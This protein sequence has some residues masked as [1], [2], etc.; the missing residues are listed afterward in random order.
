MDIKKTRT[1]KER[2]ENGVWVDFDDET[3]LLIARY[4]NPHHK[5]FSKKAMSPLKRQMRANTLP[6]K[7]YD[8]IEVKGM[9]NHVLLDWKGMKDNGKKLAYS[10]KE[11]ERLLGDPAL[12]WFAD[13]VREVS[14]DISLYREEEIEEA[15]NNLG[16]S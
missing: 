7:T 3:S 5:K 2:E 1:N 11:A 15:A 8:A 16:K 13:F 6:D 9:A 14:Q 4:M 10:V 12:D